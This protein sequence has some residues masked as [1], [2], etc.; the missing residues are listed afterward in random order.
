MSD[1]YRVRSELYDALRRGGIVIVVGLVILIP[2]EPAVQ[3]TSPALELLAGGILPGRA[4]ASSVVL[5]VGS[6]ML[7]RA[8][9][10]SAARELLFVSAVAGAVAAVAQLALLFGFAL[11]RLELWAE[12]PRVVYLGAFLWL[13]PFSAGMARVAEAADLGRAGRWWNV[14]AIVAGAPLIVLILSIAIGIVW[15]P[16]FFQRFYHEWGEP[17]GRMGNVR[18]DAP[19]LLSA[20]LTGVAAMVLFTFALELTHRPLRDAYRRERR[21]SALA[22]RRHVASV[23]GL[24]DERGG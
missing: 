6:F 4:I 20:L 24:T 12:A 2:I 18:L 3:I 17:T 16:A 21:A 11:T 5:A 14:T 13:M 15:E 19:W 9:L 1:R 7:S 22:A 10:P 8:R 23:A